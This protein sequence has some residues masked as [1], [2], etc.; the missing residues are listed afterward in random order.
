MRFAL[1]TRVRWLW[2]L[3]AALVVSLL[4]GCSCAPRQS[5][6]P[7]VEPTQSIEPSA[8]QPA[9]TSPAT[10]TPAEPAGEPKKQP[11]PPAAGE[12]RITVRAYF[13]RGEKLAVL[14]RSVPKTQAVATA[15]MEELLDGV[16][17][18]EKKAGYGTQI[19]KSTTLGSVRISGGKATVDLSR[20]FESGGGTL[21]MTLRIAQ[22][23]YTLTQFPTVDRVTFELDGKPVESI[24]G[25]GIVVAPSVD[26]ADYTDGVLPA[27]FVESPLRGQRVSSPITLRG[28]SNTFEAVYSYE[29][30][31]KAGRIL[32]KGHDTASAGTG[33][34]GTFRTRVRFEIAKDVRGVLTVY[35]VSEKDGSRINVVKI[36]VRLEH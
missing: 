28:M 34:W 16:T 35:E 13:V 9:T 11:A 12:P 19:P 18:A 3:T 32:A 30:A 20:E 23:V 15:A 8:A 33:T 2:V 31:D 26:R 29:L 1:T 24:G 4:V 10:T 14:A 27:I 5:P 7:T 21:S 22:V 25:E 17:A 36:P 6:A